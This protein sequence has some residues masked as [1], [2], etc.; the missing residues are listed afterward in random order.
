MVF[1]ASYNIFEQSSKLKAMLVGSKLSFRLDGGALVVLCEL[2]P[3]ATKVWSYMLRT[4]FLG[5][6][7]N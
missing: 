6:K 5:S 7:A 2:E 1:H 3:T 4:T